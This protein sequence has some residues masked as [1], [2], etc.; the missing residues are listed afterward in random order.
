MPVAKADTP[1][2]ACLLLEDAAASTLVGVTFLA[3]NAAPDPKIVEK[4]KLLEPLLE[5]PAHPVT[6]TLFHLNDE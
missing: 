2:R 6:W 1:R 5:K 3:E 4:E